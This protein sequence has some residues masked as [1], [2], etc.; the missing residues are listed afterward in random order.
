MNDRSSL[1]ENKTDDL[2]MVPMMLKAI[3]FFRRFGRRIVIT[4]LLGMIVGGFLYY[5][6]PRGYKAKS[7]FQSS[8]LSNG[9][10]LRVVTDWADLLSRNNRPLAAQVFNMPEDRIVQVHDINAELIPGNEDMGGLTIEVDIS[11]TTVLPALQSGMVYALNNNP[12][13]KQ[14]IEIK[15]KNMQDVLSQAQQELRRLDSV[16]PY[17]QGLA[18]GEKDASGKVILDMA[19]LSLQRM[20]CEDRIGNALERLHFLAGAYVLQG[21]I[22]SKSGKQLP[23]PVLPLLGLILGFLIGY[24]SASY[25]VFKEKYLVVAKPGVVA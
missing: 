25:T 1:R 22:V 8:I 10:G 9:Q 3:V 19:N 6:M 4:S 2:D 23:A 12:Y 21:F 13:I 16:K 20:A 15:R 5:S 17:L 18:G 24:G 7:V 14:R 11:D